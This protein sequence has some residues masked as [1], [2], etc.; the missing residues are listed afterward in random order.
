MKRVFLLLFILAG[1]VCA[2]DVQIKAFPYKDAVIKKMD[3]EFICFEV[4]R[5]IG[6]ETKTKEYKKKSTDIQYVR[7]VPIKKL[8]I[9]FEKFNKAERF[10]KAGENEKAIKLYR[11]SIELLKKDQKKIKQ[12]WLKAIGTKEA[13]GLLKASNIKWPGVLMQFRLD[14][15][16]G[17]EVKPDEV[18]KTKVSGKNFCPICQGRRS[19]RCEA[20]RGTGR[21]KCEECHGNW[22]KVCSHCKGTTKVSGYKYKTRRTSDG[23]E[24]RRVSSKVD[25]EWCKEIITVGRKKIG[26]SEKC[27]FCSGNR[28]PGYVDCAVCEGKKEFTCTACNGTGLNPDPMP[29]PKKPSQAEAQDGG[30]SSK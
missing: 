1:P 23:R 3:A 21:E 22:Y 10:R 4:T 15:L 6:G 19:I 17:E 7:L 8:E 30:V 27:E 13:D 11:E 2:D 5:K 26:I 20:C 14:Q 25:C 29:D 18:V 16:T 9:P 12:E 28:D 24:T